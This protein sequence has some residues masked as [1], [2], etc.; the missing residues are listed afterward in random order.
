MSNK[1]LKLGLSIAV[2][3]ALVVGFLWLKPDDMRPAS[4]ASVGDQKQETP[5]Q[6]KD[7]SQSQPEKGSISGSFTFP[8]STVPAD[9][10]ACAE[11]MSGEKVVCSESQLKDG[12]YIYGVGYELSLPAGE[13][14]VYAT[15]GDELIRAYYNQYSASVTPDGE[16]PEYDTSKCQPSDAKLAVKVADGQS[17]ENIT[18]ADWYFETSCSNTN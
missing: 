4:Q 10:V 12:K 6:Q 11:D 7:T 16:W 18:L 5:N 8:S 15:T 2:I 9:L 14:Y 3:I 13:Y 1:A 17:T